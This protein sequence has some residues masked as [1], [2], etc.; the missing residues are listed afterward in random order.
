MT[1]ETRR[2][3][4]IELILGGFS[5]ACWLAAIAFL[6]VENLAPSVAVLRPLA[7]WGQP[8]VAFALPLAVGSQA[9]LALARPAR[10]PRWRRFQV[11]MLV[12]AAG[13]LLVAIWI[14]AR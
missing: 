4:P 5:L 8:V 7:P 1:E 9:V 11:A 6:I 2:A 10:S 12:L 14:F 13:L 3:S